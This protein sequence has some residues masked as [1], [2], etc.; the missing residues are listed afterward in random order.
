MFN[1]A[2]FLFPFCE[3]VNLCACLV[4]ILEMGTESLCF[5][6]ASLVDYE[7]FANFVFGF[8]EFN[9]YDCLIC[10]VYFPLC[11]IVILDHLKGEIVSGFNELMQI[12]LAKSSVE[13][14]I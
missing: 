7:L 3:I 9:A 4:D 6:N 5:F 14:E 11:E 8:V 2:S 13:A 10:F 1:I 12:Y